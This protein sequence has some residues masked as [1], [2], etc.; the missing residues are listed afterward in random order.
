MGREKRRFMVLAAHR[1]YYMEGLFSHSA[2]A[3]SDVHASKCMLLVN[4]S[5]EFL[6]VA[7]ERNISVQ[8]VSRAF[9][10]PMRLSTRSCSGM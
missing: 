9:W 2:S 10:G 3:F 4:P 6:S 5:I 7:I 8:S 1:S